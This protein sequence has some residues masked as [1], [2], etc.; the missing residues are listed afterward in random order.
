MDLSL[1]KLDGFSFNV[2]SSMRGTCE[3]LSTN[4]CQD[5]SH[6]LDIH[7]IAH[8]EALATN[9]ISSHFLELQYIDKFANKVYLWLERSAKRHGGVNHFKS[10]S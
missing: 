2:A 10:L 1:M 7:Y 8:R 6:L 9:D 4:F 5:A 3:G